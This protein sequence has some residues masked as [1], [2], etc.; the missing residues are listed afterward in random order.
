MHRRK[1]P[2]KQ[3]ISRQRKKPRSRLSRIELPRRKLKRKL[4]NK[5]RSRQGKQL[6][7]KPETRKRKP[8]SRKSLRKNRLRN[9]LS[10]L[11]PSEKL[12]FQVRLRT[13]RSQRINYQN[14]A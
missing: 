7:K 6:S 13:G 1:W 4:L 9:K 12:R 10:L 5:L 2:K 14:Q 8:E 11:K 3:P